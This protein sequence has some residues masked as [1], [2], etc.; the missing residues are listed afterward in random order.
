MKKNKTIVAAA[1]VALLGTHASAT[2]RVTAPPA[3]LK[4][5]AYY[6]KYLD[7]SGVPVVAHGTVD[8]AALYKMK[9]IVDT[10]LW[11]DAATR[12]QV[13]AR[14]RRVLVIPRNDG[15]TTLPEYATLDQT[16]PIPG[17]TWNARAQGVGWT[18][19]L[20]YMSCSEANLLHS[21]WPLDR[22]V[23]ESICIHEFAHAVW[24]AGL[25][26]RDGGAQGRLNALWA[27]DKNSGFLGTT[28]SSQYAREYWAE[29]V[30]AWFN[31]ASCSNPNTTP[32]CT[33]N[34]LYRYDYP[35]WNEIGKWFYAPYQLPA[36]I[37]P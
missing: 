34:A 24:D 30:Q 13:V 31:A 28:Y 36:Q 15:M 35:L 2:V 6:T 8:D 10:M 33:H 18:D 3:Y 27:W 37:Y 19:A 17:S 20:P 22:Y 1:V 11:K 5:P 26:F 32:T 14:L 12:Q 9:T 23:D 25:V 29:G 16:N 21:G 4:L 7:A